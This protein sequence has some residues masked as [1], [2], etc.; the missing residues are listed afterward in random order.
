MKP[1]MFAFGKWRTLIELPQCPVD[2]KTDR[3]VKLRLSRA[4]R[5]TAVDSHCLRLQKGATIS[6]IQGRKIGTD[7]CL[8]DTREVCDDSRNQ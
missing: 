7:D 3:K 1:P 8:P 5:F 4:G 6:S 2:T